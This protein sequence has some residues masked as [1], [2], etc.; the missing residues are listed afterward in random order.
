[1][2]KKRLLNGEECPKCKEVSKLLEER[3]HAGDI[4]RTV[5]ADMSDPQSEGFALAKKYRVK[6][7][8]FFIVRREG[9]E[10]IYTSVLQMLNEVFGE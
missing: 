7:A 6:R 10:K 1:M 8:P 2:V 3:G 4:T 9:E 5:W